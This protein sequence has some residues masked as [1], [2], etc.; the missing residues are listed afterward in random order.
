MSQTADLIKS[1]L[2]AKNIMDEATR[3]ASRA[4]TDL[5]NA[6]NNLGKRL[7]VSPDGQET[8]EKVVVWAPLDEQH[9]RMLVIKKTKGYG[10]GDY[11][12]EFLGEKRK[13]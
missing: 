13:I 10:R 12:M 6:L 3:V 9:E 7:M 5:I 4:D 1:W 11:H 2:S 8:P